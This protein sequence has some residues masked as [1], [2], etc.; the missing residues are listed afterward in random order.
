MAT[1]SVRASSVLRAAVDY[2]NPPDDVD[3]SKWTKDQ[4]KIFLRA[5]RAKLTG[6]RDELITRYV[7]C[8]CLGIA[9]GIIS[10]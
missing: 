8:C 7:I 10:F 9:T 3:F 5:R 4:L 2:K 1:S 6:R